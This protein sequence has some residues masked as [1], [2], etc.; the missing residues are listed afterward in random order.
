MHPWCRWSVITT[1]TCR[2]YCM[3]QHTSPKRE[4][5]G[6][7]KRKR[8]AR[9][10]C[11]ERVLFAGIVLLCQRFCLNHKLGLPHSRW[12]CDINQSSSRPTPGVSL[13]FTRRRL[14]VN[15]HHHHHHQLQQLHC[16]R[17]TTETRAVVQFA[18]TDRRRHVISKHLAVAHT[19]RMWRHSHVPEHAYF[20]RTVNHVIKRYTKC[21]EMQQNKQFQSCS[22]LCAA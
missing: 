2:M 15:H 7:I 19:H 8:W 13:E 18:T 16:S 20:C 17:T 1:I 9:Q 11:D 21:D 6:E 10:K 4:I 12:R 3:R 5:N 22:G 14:S